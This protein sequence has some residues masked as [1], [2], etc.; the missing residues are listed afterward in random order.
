M[1]DPITF[2]LELFWVIGWNG[3]PKKHW[4]KGAIFAGG[5]CI[6]SVFESL[7]CISRGSKAQLGVLFLYS[8]DLFFSGFIL[9]KYSCLNWGLLQQSLPEC[10]HSTSPKIKL[11]RKRSKYIASIFLTDIMKAPHI[12]QS[13]LICKNISQETNDS[14]D[15]FSGVYESPYFTK[16]LIASYLI[17]VISCIGLNFVVWFERSGGAGHYRTLVNQLTSFNLDQ[18][19]VLNK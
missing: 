12:I 9:L 6:N 11:S 16:L 18:V 4:Y 7:I 17:G 3:F 10:F 8:R 2:V 15:F 14:K 19:Q 5:S 1:N 13:T